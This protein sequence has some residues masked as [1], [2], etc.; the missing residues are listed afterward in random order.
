MTPALPKHGDLLCT[1]TI[2]KPWLCDHSGDRASYRNALDV[3]VR[4]NHLDYRLVG[5]SGTPLA[6]S[7][8]VSSAEI[9]RPRFLAEPYTLVW[10][11]FKWLDASIG[12]DATGRRAEITV[13]SPWTDAS[14]T[15]ELA[16]RAITARRQ[17]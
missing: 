6:L 5:A 14:L 13:E 1:F 2:L 17:A 11:I 8:V 15:R 3:F 10:A 16:K 12:A 4:N 7:N 9:N